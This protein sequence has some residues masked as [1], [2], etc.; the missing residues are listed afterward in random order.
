M[1][2]GAELTYET[3]T[4]TL[5]GQESKGI[6]SH[7]YGTTYAENNNAQHYVIKT[8]TKCSYQNKTSESHSANSSSLWTYTNSTTSQHIINKKCTKCNLTFTSTGT[9][10][11]GSENSSWVYES[12]GHATQH[13]ITSPCTKCNQTYQ[14]HSDVDWR[15]R[16]ISDTEHVEET[17]CETCEQ[18]RET[19][20]SEHS[21]DYQPELGDYE[22][23][24]ASDS[25]ACHCGYQHIGTGNKTHFYRTAGCGAVSCVCGETTIQGTNHHIVGNM[26]S[27][28]GLLLDRLS[29][30]ITQENVYTN[31]VD[32]MI[33]GLWNF[34]GAD[35][36][37]I[38]INGSC[39]SYDFVFFAEE[40]NHSPG[41][42]TARKYLST[43]G[44]ISDSPTTIPAGSAQII[45]LE[46]PRQIQG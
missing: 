12:T 46:M 45:N 17:Y 5:C 14:S 26:C 8:C 25:W 15:V 36:V 38:T 39:E 18:W 9:H 33:V 35:S 1:A 30:S 37:T 27:V 28:C 24:T 21:A 10:S 11:A 13:T 29:V 42:S 2:N 22:T 4:C 40:N 43:S 20:R 44:R 16:S 6:Y 31:N 32:G 3:K 23:C 34:E 7:T 41:L 19:Y